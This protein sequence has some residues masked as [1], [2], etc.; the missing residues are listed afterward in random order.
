MYRMLR[1]FLRV[2]IETGRGS[3]VNVASEASSIAG[4]PNR[5]ASGTAKAAMIGLTKAVAA[6]FVRVNAICLG[7]GQSPS[8]D[9]RVVPRK[10]TTQYENQ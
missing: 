7:T 6:D 3:I 2:M 9:D 10:T 8:R 5:F 1:A 4:V